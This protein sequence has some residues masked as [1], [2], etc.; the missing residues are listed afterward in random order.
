MKT[1]IKIPIYL[2]IESEAIDRR[3]ISTEARR[4][5]QPHVI[6]YLQ[7]GDFRNSV[8]AEYRKAILQK[9]AKVRIVSELELL[10]GKENEHP[11]PDDLL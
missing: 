3:L 1:I 8:L 10:S 9:S 7:G 6:K 11:N 2:E 5:L 4:V